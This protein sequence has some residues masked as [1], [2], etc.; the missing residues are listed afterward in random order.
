MA[1]TSGFVALW[2][3][4]YGKPAPGQ[5]RPPSKTPNTSNLTDRAAAARESKRAKYSLAERTAEE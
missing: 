1:I 3:L 5:R 4:L 2:Q